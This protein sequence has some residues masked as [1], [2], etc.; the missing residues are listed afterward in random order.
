MSERNKYCQY[1]LSS[2]TNWTLTNYAEHA[3]GM[4]HDRI[5]RY[6]REAK[7]TPK[8]LWEQVKDD[9][10]QSPNGFIVFDDPVLDR[11]HG[12]EIEPLRTSGAV[13]STGS[14]RGSGW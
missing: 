3:E 5:N 9:V 7:L 10:V 6:L 8:L 4:S 14:S 2:Q 12:R 1:L 13:T 11:R